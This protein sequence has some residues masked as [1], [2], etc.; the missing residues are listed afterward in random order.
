MPRKSET[1]LPEKL[2]AK[3]VKRHLEGGESVIPLAKEYGVSRA[4]FYN[5]ISTY[6]RQLLKAVDKQGMSP[7]DAAT[8]DKRTLLAEMHQLKLE[9]TA[10]RNKVVAMMLKYKEI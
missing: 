8:A 10:L 9:N 4:T 3:A 6:E 2:V 5:W 7:R 1:K